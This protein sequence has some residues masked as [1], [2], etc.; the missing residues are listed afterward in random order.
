MDHYSFPLRILQKVT[1]LEDHQLPDILL[2]HSHVSMLYQK[3][4][5]MQIY[6]TLI[7]I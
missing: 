4:M 5:T 6:E 7:V 3:L 2:L 1:I